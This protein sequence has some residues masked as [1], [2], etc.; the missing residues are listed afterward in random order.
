MVCAGRHQQDRLVDGNNDTTGAITAIETLTTG[1]GWVKVAPA[2]SVIG[3]AA[4]TDHYLGHS[5]A[6]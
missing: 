3:A 5:R 6:G 1:L 2:L 4:A